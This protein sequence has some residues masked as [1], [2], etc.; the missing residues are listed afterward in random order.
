MDV[1]VLLAATMCGVMA[2]VCV[3]CL[4]VCRRSEVRAV[5]AAEAAEID[6]A[7]VRRAE[8]RVV[9][10]KV[11][12]KAYWQMAQ[13]QADRAA[14]FAAECKVEAAK[15]AS[16]MAAP[17]EVATAAYP[18]L[19]PVTTWMPKQSGGVCYTQVQVTDDNEADL[20]RDSNGGK[21]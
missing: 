7:M 4:V 10:D 6:A 1:V 9:D 18:G 20:N 16:I 14:E 19:V 13:E 21:A 11:H 15:V 8:K 12:A 2:V 5:D 3:C 17:L